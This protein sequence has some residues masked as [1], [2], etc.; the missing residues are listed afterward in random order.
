MKN[1]SNAWA[2]L[3]KSW[4]PYKKFCILSGPLRIS[5]TAESNQT[6]TCQ[7]LD[8]HQRE[9]RQKFVLWRVL[10]CTK[11]PSLGVNNKSIPHF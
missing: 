5:N 6:L 2:E 8:I 11:K 3:K 7:H 10:G 1:L 4:V 9:G